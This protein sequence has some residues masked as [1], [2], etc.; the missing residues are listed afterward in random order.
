MENKNNNIYGPHERGYLEE[1]PKIIKSH[2]AKDYTIL[3][4]PVQ[5]PIVTNDISNAEFDYT[6]NGG[7][8]ILE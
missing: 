1:K 8:D 5:D 7:D 2:S 6:Y 4:D 3:P